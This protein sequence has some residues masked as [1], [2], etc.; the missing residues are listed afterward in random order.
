MVTEL[1]LRS[2]R[3]YLRR[4]QE[5]GIVVSF[6]VIFGSQVTGSA[7][8]WSDIDVLV[9]SPAFD[10]LTSRQLVNLLWRVAAQTDSRIEPI[11]CGL[12]RWYEDDVSPLVE[13]ARRE[14]QQVVVS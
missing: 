9:V 12:Q 10:R 4:L 2:V 8:E 5:H 14:G 6:G 3:R 7:D 11:P 13:L 1:V